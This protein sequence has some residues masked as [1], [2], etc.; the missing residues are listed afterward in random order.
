MANCQNACLGSS[1]DVLSAILAQDTSVLVRWTQVIQAFETAGGFPQ[2]AQTINS[3][4][5]TNVNNCAGS[6]SGLYA[7]ILEQRQAI[8]NMLQGVILAI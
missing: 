6:T 1:N 2:S 7:N 5:S 8:F 3:I 4:L